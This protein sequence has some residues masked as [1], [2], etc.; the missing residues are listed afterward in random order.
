MQQIAGNRR[1]DQFLLRQ[2]ARSSG[3]VQGALEGTTLRLEPS[4]SCRHSRMRRYDIRKRRRSATI[5]LARPGPTR[6]HSLQATGSR[7]GSSTAPV[8]ARAGV[9]AAA[10]EAVLET[11]IGDAQ[12]LPRPFDIAPQQIDRLETGVVNP[13]ACRPHPADRHPAPRC[14]PRRRPRRSAPRC[15]PTGAPRA[16]GCWAAERC[17]SDSAAV[18]RALPQDPPAAAATACATALRPSSGGRRHRAG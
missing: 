13:G 10:A 8:P 6:R 3:L 18:V 17:W 5:K 2:R 16:L 1:I 12:V 14:P 9:M 7:L 11:M 15:P 4:Q